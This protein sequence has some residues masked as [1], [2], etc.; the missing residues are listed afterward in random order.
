[1]KV[2]I[3]A[4]GR[5]LGLCRVRI[6]EEFQLVCI[7]GELQLVLFCARESMGW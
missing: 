2:E 7:A 5:F 6:A 4:T 3:Q 1:M